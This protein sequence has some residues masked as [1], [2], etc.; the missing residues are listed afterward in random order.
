VLSI[1]LAPLASDL[2]PLRKLPNA[3]NGCIDKVSYAAMPNNLP[4]NFA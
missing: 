1:T 2:V 4:M 3:H